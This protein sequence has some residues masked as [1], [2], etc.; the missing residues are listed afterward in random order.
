L[1]INDLGELIVRAPK[2][3]SMNFIQKAIEPRKNWIQQKQEVVKKNLSRY[4]SKVFINGEE[5]L[6]LGR[7]YELSVREDAADIFQFDDRF[8]ILSEKWQ[9]KA[10]ALFIYWY[11]QRAGKIIGERVK[12]FSDMYGFSCGK[13]KISN[14]RKRWGS[15]PAREGTI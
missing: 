13:V 4:K 6:F 12:H 1:E 7:S 15:Y 8:F 9:I 5:F 2:S 3:V 11:K 10:R 14:A